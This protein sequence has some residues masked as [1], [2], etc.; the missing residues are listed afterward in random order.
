MLA[1]ETTV[2]EA[3]KAVL[4]AVV[5]AYHQGDIEKACSHTHPECTLDGKPFGREGDLMRSKMMA[6]AW[7]DQVWKWDSLIA[8][9][10]WVAASYTFKGTF[11]GPMGDI[12]PNGKEIVFTGV[13]VY[14]FQGGQITEIWEYYDRLGL[15]Q[16]MGVIPALG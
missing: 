16:Q 15:Y 3:N 9:G 12:P 11:S 4:H 8:E 7:P 14:R 5:E 10:E 13:S 6:T 1:Q 2:Q